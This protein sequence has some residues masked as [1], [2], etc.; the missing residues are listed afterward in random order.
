VGFVIHVPI[1]DEPWCRFMFFVGLLAG[2]PAAVWYIYIYIY[3]S[4]QHI[5]DIFKS[6]LKQL[7]LHMGS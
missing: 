2:G 7:S 6:S 3:T 4:I 1:C 5:V